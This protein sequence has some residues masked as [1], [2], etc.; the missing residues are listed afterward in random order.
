MIDE[1]A[2]MD[3]DAETLFE[4]VGSR[5]SVPRT[6]RRAT[7][8]SA[9]FSET[10]PWVSRAAIVKSFKTGAMRRLMMASYTETMLRTEIAAAFSTRERAR[11]A[12]DR[13][14]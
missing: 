8:V 3:H 2:A 1:G 11:A 9:T 10:A 5:L 14:A 7:S 13:S 4:L 12:G 6:G